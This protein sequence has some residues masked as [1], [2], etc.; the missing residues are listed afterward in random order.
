MDGH[1][2]GLSLKGSKDGFMKLTRWDEGGGDPV[3]S[4]ISYVIG[5]RVELISK[6]ETK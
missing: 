3:M 2:K 5:C 1:S 4:R 6:A